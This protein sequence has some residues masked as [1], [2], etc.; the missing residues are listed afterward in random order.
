MAAGGNLFGLSAEAKARLLQKLSSVASIRPGAALGRRTDTAEHDGGS[1]R[2]D[3]AELEAYR[4]IRLIEQAAS[5]P[6]VLAEK[7]YLDQIQQLI[8]REQPVT[9]LWESQR[10]TAVNK[11]VKDVR[12][13]LAFSFFNLKEWWL[14]PKP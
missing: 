5:Q 9:F 2:L 6:D 10:L 13:T 4:E 1:G 3:V 14:A 11:R 8:H 7:P 12:P